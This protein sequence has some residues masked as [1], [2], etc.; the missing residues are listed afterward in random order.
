MY[1]LLIFIIIFYF[2]LIQ[3]KLLS[4]MKISYTN[5]NNILLNEPSLLVCS[6]DYEQNDVFILINEFIKNKQN[7]TLVVA[8]IIGHKILMYY[9]K[10]IGVFNIDF[11]FIKDGTVNK[12]IDM[13][14]KDNSI[15]T[16]LRRDDNSH[17]VYYT[18]LEEEVPIILC[19][20]K[21]DYLKEGEYNSIIEKYTFNFNKE[22][23]IEYKKYLYSLIN[24][25]DLFMNNLL[26]RLYNK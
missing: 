22:Y 9:I 5:K 17:G 20:I 25:E 19:Q 21:S 10:F 11:L 24:D 16:F 3:I 8:D 23:Q 12:M 15:I 2:V 26:K 1:K 18:I 7:V 13:L 4:L 6:H 14:K